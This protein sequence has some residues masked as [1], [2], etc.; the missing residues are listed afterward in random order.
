MDKDNGI[1]DWVSD[2]NNVYIGRDMTQHVKGAEG[3]K[4]A[5]KYGDEEW[6]RERRVDQ[7][8]ALIKRTPELYQSLEELQG[9]CLGCWCVPERC[10][11]HA[12]IKLLEEKL[13]EKS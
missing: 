12:L 3:S 5:N 7:Y 9:K 6:T 2:P 11:G 8:E 10:H 1:S 4:W 13:K